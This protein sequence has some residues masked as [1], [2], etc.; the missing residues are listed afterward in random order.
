MCGIVGVVDLSGRPL[1]PAWVEG[2]TR[3]LT[4]R[5]PDDEGYCFDGFI[6]LLGRRLASRWEG[7]CIT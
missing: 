7:T 6:V 1:E 2:M 3:F 4:H 5:G